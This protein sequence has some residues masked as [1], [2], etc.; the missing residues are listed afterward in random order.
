MAKDID[1]MQAN[2]VIG[3]L[4]ASADRLIAQARQLVKEAQQMKQ[5]ADDLEQ[6]VK[7]HDKRRK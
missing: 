5:R 1:R 3:E 2:E 7:Q 6:L 4:R